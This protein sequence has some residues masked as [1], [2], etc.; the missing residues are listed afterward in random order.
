MC[1]DTSDS[2]P[3][4]SEILQQPL[5]VIQFDLRTR[6]F[7]KAL[8]QFFQNAPRALGIDFA[9][10][11]PNPVAVIPLEDS[12]FAACKSAIKWFEYGRGLSK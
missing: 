1:T 2:P 4:D 11:L 12:R 5:D 9:R 10:Q 8:A 6:A 7:A 3:K